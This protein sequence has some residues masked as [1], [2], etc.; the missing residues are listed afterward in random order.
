MANCAT[1]AVNARRMRQRSL[2]EFNAIKLNFKDEQG[3]QSGK[4]I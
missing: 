1:V 2:K 3:S 4:I